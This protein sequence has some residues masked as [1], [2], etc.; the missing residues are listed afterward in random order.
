M[1]LFLSGERLTLETLDYILSV[2][3]VHQPFFISICVFK[4]SYVQRCGGF[5]GVNFEGVTFMGN[6]PEMSRLI[7]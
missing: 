5:I 3:A 1:F 7:V 2:L 6:I 4:L